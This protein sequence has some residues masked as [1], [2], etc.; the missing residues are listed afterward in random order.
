MIGPG[1]PGGR[2]MRAYWQPVARGADVSAGQA[3]PIRIL[4]EKFTLYRGE[5]GRVRLVDNACA[6]R[7]SKA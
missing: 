2:Y 6:H 5:G 1:T 4:G 3:I 7:G